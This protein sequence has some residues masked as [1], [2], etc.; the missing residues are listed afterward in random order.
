[1]S[2]VPGNALEEAMMRAVS[3]AA[4]RVDFYRLLLET[5][6]FVI[7]QI[8]DREDEGPTTLRENDS[9]SI[10]TLVYQQK[11]YH[12]LF[13]SEARLNAFVNGPTR[14][15]SMQGRALFECTRGAEFLLNPGSEL[16]KIM[17]PEEIEHI[18][19]NAAKMAP[20]S[21]KLSP[22][23]VYPKKLVQALCV[24]FV[25]RSQVDAAHLHYV[26][27]EGDGG[28][29]HP[30]IAIEAEGD[31]QLLLREVQVAA[32]AAMPGAVVDIVGVD[33]KTQLDPFRKQL[34]GNAPFYRR[35]IPF[36]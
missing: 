4:A 35:T 21:I 1:M 36:H 10:G 7:G 26:S 30:L 16:S 24:L 22:P 32:L 3:D 12:P 28:E 33:P 8:A 27:R 31:T 17:V 19:A 9:L 5:E 18:L 25:S 23:A 15:F 14:F 20:I 34:I 6:L 13:S 29:P 2:F 11:T